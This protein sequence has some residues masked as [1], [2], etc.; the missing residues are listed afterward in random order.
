VLFR[1]AK[2]KYGIILIDTPPVIAVTDPSVLSP[3]VDGV[4]LVIRSGI[5]QREAAVR[6]IEQLRRVEAP[7]L[8]VLLN[9]L[10]VNDMY[11]SYYY[12]YYYY[13]EGDGEHKKKK[14]KIHSSYKPM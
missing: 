7:L 12:Y 5:T 6:A 9:D 2:E 13:Y 11:G 1:S 10:K 14:S 3:I 4:I 8:G